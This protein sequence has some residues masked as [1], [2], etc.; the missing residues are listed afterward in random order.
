MLDDK[1]K[2]EVK[3][4]LSPLKSEVEL[5][6]FVSETC[7]YCPQE[8]ELLS[9]ISEVSTVKVRELNIKSDEAKKL[10]VTS[11]PVVVF[12]KYPNIKFMGLPSGHEFR[13]FLDTI[14]M[15]DSGKTELKDEVKLELKKLD[16]EVDLKVFVTP[17]CPYCPQAVFIAHQFAMEN[18]KVTSTMVESMEFPDLAQKHGVMSVPK[19]VINDEKSWEGAAPAHAVLKKIM[20]A[21]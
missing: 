16:K 1:N 11:A 12:S 19:T 14:L 15:V 2:T 4:I 10:K 8:K 13:N 17:T 9:Q 6:F 20:E 21:V 5:L 3:K 7:E 18:P